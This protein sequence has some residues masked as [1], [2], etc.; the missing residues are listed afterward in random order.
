MYTEHRYTT[1]M[2]SLRIVK[3]CIPIYFKTYEFG[4][5]EAFKY[6]TFIDGIN[7]CHNLIKKYYPEAKIIF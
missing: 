3:Q 7:F 1:L 4:D 2:F 6:E 5:K